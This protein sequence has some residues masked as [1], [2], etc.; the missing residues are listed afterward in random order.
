[1]EKYKL[2]QYAGATRLTLDGTE[3]SIKAALN[4]LKQF[5]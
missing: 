4:L 1:M 5:Y 3:Q 2:S